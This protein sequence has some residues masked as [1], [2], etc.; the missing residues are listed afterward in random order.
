MG[1]FSWNRD[2]LKFTQNFTFG[3]FGTQRQSCLWRNSTLGLKQC[4]VITEAPLSNRTV[5]HIFIKSLIGV[6]SMLFKNEPNH[7]SYCKDNKV[8]VIIF[9]LVLVIFQLVISVLF[10]I[11][12]FALLI[13]FCVYFQ[14]SS[15]FIQIYKCFLP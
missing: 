1:T 15:D 10:E 11:K 7:R 8:N 5:S 6:I 14:R 12:T 9:Y 4:L 3:N 2:H 13:V